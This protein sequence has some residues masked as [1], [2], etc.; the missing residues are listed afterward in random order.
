MTNGHL[1]NNEY[2]L[3][4]T[5]ERYL[6]QLQANAFGLAGENLKSVLLLKGLVSIDALTFALSSIFHRHDA[7]RTIVFPQEGD[8]PAYQKVQ[9][10]IEPIIEVIDIRADQRDPLMEV[11]RVASELVW[12]RFIIGK[13]VLSRFFII[14]LPDNSVVVGMVTHHIV[15]DKISHSIM[16]KEL[17][18]L[19]GTH[20]DAGGKAYKKTVEFRDFIAARSLWD[21]D[22]HLHSDE[23]FW[24]A[25]IDFNDLNFPPGPS[26]LGNNAEVYDPQSPVYFDI[27]DINALQELAKRE[28][29]TL[30]MVLSSLLCAACHRWNK[31]GGLLY[32]VVKDERVAKYQ[33]VVGFF[34]NS[35]P[36]HIDFMGENIT[37]RDILTRVKKEHLAMLTNPWVP[38]K[39]SEFVDQATEFSK[40]GKYFIVDYIQQGSD[41]KIEGLDV[42]ALHIPYPNEI[43]YGIGPAVFVFSSFGEAYIGYAMGDVLPYGPLSEYILRRINLLIPR[44]LLDP[45]VMLSELSAVTD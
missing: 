6:H 3:G 35:Y 12:T 23:A 10:N 45:D 17:A 1:T 11:T 26:A 37:F 32:L 9:E 8:T 13:D 21:R 25:K 30:F 41:L 18:E 7:L 24:D 14:K 4:A 40:E 42:S 27:R 29:V 33:A 19:Y 15:S 2:P 28:R 36:I 44:I 16:C 5:Q 38:E 43:T 39:Y 20:S 31:K 22:W 34:T